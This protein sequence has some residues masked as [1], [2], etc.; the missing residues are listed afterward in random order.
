M[1]TCFRICRL[2][3][4]LLFLFFILLFNHVFSPSL[5]IYTEL[6]IPIMSFC[7]CGTGFLL[8]IMALR[9]CDLWS[10]AYHLKL[11]EIIDEYFVK[12]KTFLFRISW[13]PT[14]KVISEM[15][16]RIF[17]HLFCEMFKIQRNAFEFDEY[18]HKVFETFVME[19]IE[20]RPLDWLILVILFL[21]NLART[22]LNF[23]YYTCDEYDTECENT[24]S[25]YMY[26]LAGSCIFVITVIFAVV[27]RRLELLIMARRGVS[28]WELYAAYL[29]VSCVRISVFVS[30]ICLCILMY[31]F[32][33]C[34]Y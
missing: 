9:Q 32:L 21:L 2:V 30:F 11:I 17:H 28:S 14:V 24:S 8:V 13:K 6:L 16:F 15:E 12:S 23:S 33:H 22:K 4:F 3:C 27:S 18:V 10:K 29:Q 26:V 5:F 34:G 7:Y 1:D 19:I 25:M 31:E 20:I